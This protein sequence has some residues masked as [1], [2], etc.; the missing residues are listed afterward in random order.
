MKGNRR[1]FP[2]CIPAGLIASIRLD[3]LPDKGFRNATEIPPVDMSSRHVPRH[4]RAGAGGCEGRRRIVHI[5]G[6]RILPAGR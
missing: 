4:L 1:Y 3:I 2:V 5:A 6:M